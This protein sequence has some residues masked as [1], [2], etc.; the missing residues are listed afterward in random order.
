MVLTHD[1]E[2]VWDKPVDVPE[3]WIQNVD[4]S[5]AGSKL[6]LPCNLKSSKSDRILIETELPEGSQIKGIFPYGASY[7]T[8]TAEIQTLQADESSQSFF[9]K[10]RSPHSQ[11]FDVTTDPRT[12]YR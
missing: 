4:P 7:W 9:L 10:V 2:P 5:V 1:N 12:I 11:P 6:S 8:R 3:K